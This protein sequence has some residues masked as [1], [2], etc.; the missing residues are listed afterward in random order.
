VWVD[1][2]GRRLATT[3]HAFEQ[4]GDEPTI[5]SRHTTIAAADT[6][7]RLFDVPGIAPR[8]AVGGELMTTQTDGRVLVWDEG[9]AELADLGNIRVLSAAPAESPDLDPEQRG[10]GRHPLP[11]LVARFI[12]VTTP[13]AVRQGNSFHL[14]IH[15]RSH[16]S[17]TTRR[18][19]PST[20][21]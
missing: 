1:Q 16:S 20:C 9:G 7:A 14:T 8:F 15:L 2:A 19:P 13:V 18:C 12:D 17:P 4:I 6:G 10:P 21:R 5:R 11:D 3:H